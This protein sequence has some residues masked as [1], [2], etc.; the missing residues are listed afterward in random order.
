MGALGAGVCCDG[1]YGIGVKS[2]GL[3]LLG[4]EVMLSK[5]VGE[6]KMYAEERG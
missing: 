5:G 2:L 1:L 3:G 6:R 4:G